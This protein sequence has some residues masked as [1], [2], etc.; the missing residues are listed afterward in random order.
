MK[1]KVNKLF[2]SILCVVMVPIYSAEGQPQQVDASLA[3]KEA[4]NKL[5]VCINNDTCKN[6]D[7]LEQFTNACRSTVGCVD[8]LENSEQGNSKLNAYLKSKGI[9]TTGQT[10][11]AAVAGG[12]DITEQNNIAFVEKR[13]AR[14][15]KLNK[16]AFSSDHRRQGAGKTIYPGTS[17]F[18]ACQQAFITA[19]GQNSLKEVYSTKLSEEQLRDVLGI[20]AADNFNFDDENSSDPEKLKQIL[21]QKT[22]DD[23][24][25]TLEKAY[26]FAKTQVR[27]CLM[28]FG[29]VE[30]NFSTSNKRYTDNDYRKENSQKSWDGRIECKTSGLE[31]IDYDECLTVLNLYNG[32]KVV[33][34]GNN[35]LQQL[36]AQ[37][38]AYEK[39]MELMQTDM[40]KVDSSTKALEVQKE[41]LGEQKDMA[42]TRRALLVA[43]IIALEA[44]AQKM[45]DPEAA[46]GLCA[47]YDVS[48]A[49]KIYPSIALLDSNEFILK[50]RPS[51]ISLGGIGNLGGDSTTNNGQCSMSF[52]GVNTKHDIL[53]NQSVKTT[54][55]AIAVEAGVDV[56]K[57]TV[58]INMLEKQEGML[59]SVIDKVNDTEVLDL[60]EGFSTQEE[61]MQYCS[62][63]PSAS[64]CVGLGTTFATQIGSGGS[65]SFGGE[66]GSNTADLSAD[67]NDTSAISTDDDEVTKKDMATSKA[68]NSVDKGNGL[69]ENKAAK[70]KVQN[71]GFAS[72]NSSGGGAGASAPGLS[73]GGSGTN[74]AVA[75]G[76]AG[77]KLASASYSG[78]GRSLSFSGG[79]GSRNKAAS[80]DGNP[81]ADMLKKNGSGSGDINFRDLA[82]KGQI[83]GKNANIFER[84]SSKYN[85]VDKKNLLL[86]YEVVD[87]N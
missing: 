76:S 18:I 62:Y 66:F 9:A 40:T 11:G 84:I 36:Q 73:G 5:A 25:S 75:G 3:A 19:T 44:A 50:P 60:P 38:F 29:T 4:A 26:S 39:Q 21:S 46:V 42:E 1:T 54:V 59:Q 2:L 85:E 16:Q 58:A 30:E 86:K 12:F 6:S 23:I 69:A 68:V 27:D 67:S 15:I 32:A 56:A 55:H 13:L 7:D 71:L 72:P 70:A 79:T 17:Q 87:K 82:S 41:G 65:I 74:S 49:G 53:A 28:M 37:D 51:Q 8:Y 33:F 35:A 47:K 78:G 48:S 45:P 63:N 31:T 20:F 34:E 10:G 64:E 61:L 52:N 80:K 14:D 83:S 77:R 81:F 24:N 57:E 43:K 22:A